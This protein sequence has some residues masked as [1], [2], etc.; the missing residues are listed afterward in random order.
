M[1]QDTIKQRLRYDK[2]SDIEAH[3]AV[4]RTLL[5]PSRE[6]LEDHPRQGRRTAWNRTAFSIRR[7]T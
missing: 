7:T 3:R 2:L 6:A 1:T 5:Q 4:V